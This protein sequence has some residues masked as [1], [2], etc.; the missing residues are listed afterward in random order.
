MLLA[1]SY[2]HKPRSVFLYS[3]RYISILVRELAERRDRIDLY[4]LSYQ[5]H[6]RVIR[7]ESDL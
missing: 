3:L 5:S 7:I 2:I 6:H 1:E 4:L